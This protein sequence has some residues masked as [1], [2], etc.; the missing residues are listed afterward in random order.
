LEEGLKVVTTLDA[1]LQA[2]AESIV[3]AAALVNVKKYNASNAALVAIDPQTG[4]ILAM[5]GSRNYFDTQIDGQF[6]AA[7]AY[8]QPGSSFKPFVYSAALLKGYTP[9]TEIFDLPTQFST[10]CAPTDNT[11]DTPPC[12]SPSDYDGKFRGPMTFTTA[13]A[14]SINVPAVKTIYLAGIPNV[15]ALATRMGITGLTEN[16]SQYGLS[17]ALGAGEVRLLDLTS[18]YAT[19]ADGGIRNPA[20]G[21]LSVTEPDGTVLEQYTAQPTQVLDPNV[22]NEM[23]SMLSNNAARYPEYPAENPLHFD[24][25]DV[26]AKTGTTNDYKDAWTVGYTPTIAVGVWAGNNDNS[27]MVKEIAGYIV[28]PMWHTFMAVA[29]AKEPKSYFTE[30]DPIPESASA[31]LRGSYN[32]PVPG[33]GTAT[34]DI[35]FWVDKDNPLGPPPTNPASDPQYAY[36]EYP[37]QQ[38]ASVVGGQ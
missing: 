1:D 28:A 15:I 13:L 33:G 14:Q 16:T 5:V 24:D 32:N 31:A 30:P 26:A 25:Y 21:I 9:D 34:H 7:L 2:Q 18:A 17:L 6:N 20:T 19:F 37:V 8:R 4:Q 35:L 12:Y 22:A 29:L 3:N 27:P 23:N 11:N 10:S 36:W 38:W